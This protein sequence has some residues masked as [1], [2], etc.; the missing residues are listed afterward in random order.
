MKLQ[1]VVLKVLAGKLNWPPAA[2]IAGLNYRR[3]DGMR[4]QYSTVG[5]DGIFLQGR[6]RR[7]RYSVPLDTVI[8]VLTLYQTHYSGC[9]LRLFHKELG[10]KYGVQVEHWWL[11]QAVRGAGLLSTPWFG[12]VDTKF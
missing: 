7:S 1:E 8:Q 10:Y 11:V 4:R 12:P 2:A 3:M 6:R 9:D 5:Y